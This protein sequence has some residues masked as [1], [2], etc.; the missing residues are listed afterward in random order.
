MARRAYIYRTEGLPVP[1]RIGFYKKAPSNPSRTSFLGCHHSKRTTM[2]DGR[3]ERRNNEKKRISDSI[4]TDDLQTAL[5]LQGG[6]AL[7]AYEAGVYAALYFWIRNGQRS[8]ENKNIFDV[9]AGTSGGAINGSIIVSHVLKKRKR[10]NVSSSSSCWKGSVRK[11]LDF[12]QHLSSSPDISKWGP[13][14]IPPEVLVSESSFPYYYRLEWPVS[15]SSWVSRWDKAHNIDTSTA[16]GEAAR[17]YYSAKEYL[18]SGAPNVF[19][20]MP[21]IPDN[22][23]FDNWFEPSNKWYQYDNSPLRESIERYASFPIASSSADGQSEQE[24]KRQPRLLMVS[25][26]VESGAVLTFDSYKKRRENERKSK[27]ED[28]ATTK[29]DGAEGREEVEI[30]YRDGILPEHVMASSSVPIHYRYA[31]VP[32]EYGN[33]STRYRK[34]WDGG[35]L[36]NTPL[37]EL[38]QA[39]EDYW[40]E[41]NQIPDLHVYI[42][43]IWPND[44]GI[45]QDHDAVVNRRNDFTYQDKTPHEEKIAYLICDYID[46]ATKLKEKLDQSQIKTDDILDAPASSKHRD[47]RPRRYGELIE[48]KVRIRE[49]TRIQRSRDPDEVSY[50]WCDY[51]EGTIFRLIKNGFKETL[52]KVSATMPG[53]LEGVL[54]QIEKESINQ[55][56]DEEE[57]LTDKQ[58]S[59]MRQAIL[60]QMSV[61]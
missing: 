30:I 52:E 56:L 32:E 22:R 19:S 29:A 45:P 21:P 31:E 14:S 34:F 59:W 41:E 61:A 12:W 60:K 28:Y 26:D 27:Y 42:V 37:R 25:V 54:S 55:E 24:E 46:L 13:F 36:S 48:K 49:V 3:R 7:A 39:H 57:R 6:G 2:T 11:L 1:R 9:I 58:A 23:F 15:E 35:L 44:R 50:K 40:R 5:V 38:I 4:R 16:T 43:N 47:G 33:Q 53:S 17:R 8:Q 10:Q 51:S 20:R 18:Y